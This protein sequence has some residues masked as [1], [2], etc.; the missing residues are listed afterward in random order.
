MH[1]G[2]LIDAR[3]INLA[4]RGTDKRAVL[5]ELAELFDELDSA[6]VL[7]VMLDREALGS[8]AAAGVAVPHGRLDV[9][10][11]Y[12]RLGVHHRGVAFDATDGQPVHVF[13]A[14]ISPTGRHGEHL[15]ALARLG[16]MLRPDVRQKLLAAPDPATALRIV[17]ATW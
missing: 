2:E 17:R 8:T 5:M 16:R 4:L 11:V 13:A 3:G 10:R 1:P 6:A 9:S 12:C 15:L 7:R 14:V